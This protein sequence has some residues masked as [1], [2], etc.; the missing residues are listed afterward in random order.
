MSGGV[1]SVDLG[2]TSD[3]DN[4]GTVTNTAGSDATIPIATSTVAGLFT[5]TEKDKLA[6][7]ED[8]AT[9]TDTNDLRYV[10]L[11]GDLSTQTVTGTGGVAVD[12]L[13]TVGGD[14]TIE[15]ITDAVGLGTDANGKVIA[16]SA[17]AAPGDG[18]I[19]I[20]QPGAGSQTFTVN[21]AGDTTITLKNDNTIVTPGDGALTIETAGEGHR[22]QAASQPTKAVQAH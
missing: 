6:G 22:Q 18:T 19:T 21:Q 15:G 9:N 7:I 14:L 13:F 20:T 17:G 4:A 12:G 3:A 16:K 5:G 11:A 8:G 1:S 2:Y 10:K